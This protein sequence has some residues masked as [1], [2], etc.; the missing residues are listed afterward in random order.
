MRASLLVV[1]L[2]A[3]IA[4]LAAVSSAIA[5]P[6]APTQPFEK[7]YTPYVS[8]EIIF[9][10]NVEADLEHHAFVRANYMYATLTDVARH[11]GGSITWGPSQSWVEVE[12]KGKKVRIV[13]GASTIFVDGNKQSLSRSTFRIDKLL[14][15]PIRSFCELFGCTVNWEESQ[16]RAYVSF[17]D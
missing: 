15:V 2:L 3:I 5:A 4:T 10:N 16:H 1:W 8:H 17:Q 6:P 11:I 14:Y 13:P 9:F 7:K 12:R